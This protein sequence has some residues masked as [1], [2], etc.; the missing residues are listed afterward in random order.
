MRP[1]RLGLR[2]EASNLQAPQMGRAPFLAI[3]SGGLVCVSGM[4]AVRRLGLGRRLTNSAAAA[5][6]ANGSKA[7]GTL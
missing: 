1:C 7:S 4:S 6:W 3:Q 5:V 2:S